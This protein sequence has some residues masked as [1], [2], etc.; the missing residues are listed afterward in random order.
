[1]RVLGRAPR[2]HWDTASRL[3]A[4]ISALSELGAQADT[5]GRVLEQAPQLL[6]QSLGLASC[7][8][9]V[10]GLGPNALVALSWSGRDCPQPVARSEASPL[11]QCLERGEALILP[12]EAGP[13]APARWACARIGG[14]A[15]G[16]L[17]ACAQAPEAFGAE[18]SLLKAAADALGLAVDR[19][20]LAAG[21][22]RSA[23]SIR[24]FIHNSPDMIFVHREGVILF[25]NPAFVARLGLRSL[26]EAV[27][28]SVL[29]YVH[30]D[31]RVTVEERMKGRAPSGLAPAEELRMLDHNG[32]IVVIEGIGIPLLLGDEPVRV[33]IARDLTE[34]KELQARIALS[35]RMVSMGTLAAGLAHELNNPLA[36]VYANLQHL[37]SKLPRALAAGGAGASLA[38]GLQAAVRDAF[39]GAE[40][41]R[42]I[43]AGVKTFTRGDAQDRSAVELGPLLDSCSSLAANEVRHRAR[44]VKDY[45]DV[46]LVLGSSGKL[47]QVFVN[48]IVNAA[49]AIPAG[50]VDANEIRLST[51]LLSDGRVC[52]EVQDTGCGIAPE[53]LPRVFDPFFTTK[54]LREGTGLGLWICQDIVVALGG[55]M[56]VESEPGRGTTFRVLLQ[57]AARA[58]AAPIGA[59]ATSSA[60]AAGAQ[61]RGRVLVVDD[62]RLVAEVIRRSLADDHD[63]EIE[64]RASSALGRLSTQRFDAVVCDLQMPEVTGMEIYRRLA[65]QAPD[66]RSPPFVFVTGGAFTP[67]AQAFLQSSKATCLDK[68]IDFVALKRCIQALMSSGG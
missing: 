29:E 30:P 14:P 4:A 33:G 21:S 16:V 45:A 40:R 5:E 57:P 22:E 15:R 3:A 58:Q 2:D 44:L 41:M 53:H 18:A 27:G 34:R 24:S 39:E 11:L 37:M 26:E 54:G 6:C 19:A 10:P 62:E 8:V 43:V 47:G 49:Q 50:A 65:E 63:V 38:G 25:V 31:D 32:R 12:G 64:T 1:M 60:A 17:V 35:N 13:S 59:S 66:G 9:L 28:R 36:Y 23:H 51:R 67:E 56:A 7:A 52:A 48:L 55:E 20:R 61:R 42:G 68:P 46:P